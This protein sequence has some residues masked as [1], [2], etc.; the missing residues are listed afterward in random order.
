LVKSHQVVATIRDFFL[1]ALGKKSLPDR[2]SQIIEWKDGIME[3]Y[4]EMTGI[5]SQ[6]RLMMTKLITEE[7][8]QD[9][10]LRKETKKSPNISFLTSSPFNSF[11]PEEWV[12]TFGK[13]TLLDLVCEI[14][15]SRVLNL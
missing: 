13:D 7:F 12:N 9:S 8:V 1:S 15:N 4:G 6:K 14:N 11:T 2:E 3:K 5:G 10:E